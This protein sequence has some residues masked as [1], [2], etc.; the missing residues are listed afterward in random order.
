MLRGAKSEPD[1][2]MP[3]MKRERVRERREECVLRVKR[4]EEDPRQDT[5]NGCRDFSVFSLWETARKL[6]RALVSETRPP[7]KGCNSEVGGAKTPRR[8]VD[9]REERVVDRAN[10]GFSR[11]KKG[12]KRGKGRRCPK[13]VRK[14]ER[15]EI[16]Q[17]VDS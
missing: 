1:G 15:G 16:K 9:E 12:E 2:G 7:R 14:K 5:K 13:I 10:C 4:Q 8:E 6:G 3:G 11:A 17:E